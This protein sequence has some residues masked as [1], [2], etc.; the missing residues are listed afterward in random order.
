MGKPVWLL[1][2]FAPDWRWM[3][4]RSDS[5]WYPSMKLFR[6]PAPDDWDAVL[7]AVIRALR[8]I[9]R[10]SQSASESPVLQTMGA[11]G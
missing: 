3:L 8:S 7:D 4:H 6:Q 2:P 1:L 11:C 5:P 9:D 10:P